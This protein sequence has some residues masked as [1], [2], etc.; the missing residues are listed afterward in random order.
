VTGSVRPGRN[1]FYCALAA[2]G[3]A[4]LAFVTDAA[5]AALSAMALAASA[6]L[7]VDFLQLR[8]VP[9]SVKVRRQ[10]P[11]AAGRG[12][13]FD[14]ALSLSNATALPLKMEVRDIVPNEA[15]PNYSVRAIDIPANG[16]A[17]L[18]ER[19]QIPTR[20]KFSFGPV[21]LRAA[22]RFGMLERQWEAECAADIKVLPATALS[23][24]ALEKD[25]RA[26][27]TLLEKKSRAPL[28]GDGMEFE[29]LSEFRDG[30]DPRRIDWRASARQLRPIVRRFTVEQHRDMLLVL[31]CGRLMGIA[32]DYRDQKGTKLDRAVDSAL[33]LANIAIDKGDRCGLALFDDKVLGF[34]PPQGG[35][36]GRKA[37]IENLYNVQSRLREANFAAM[38]A[39]LQNRQQKRALI[40]ILSD[41]V[42]VET[43][44]LF[45]GA[46]VALARRHVVIFAALRTPLLSNLLLEPV[47]STMDLTRK[48]VALRLLRAREKALHTLDHTGVHVLDVE[49]RQL[50]VPLVNKYILLRQQN[51]L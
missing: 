19:L 23:D 17:G 1:L 46:L 45:R 28:R 44:E 34:L 48:G 8:K 39:T 51:A 16:S 15:A 35:A 25:E 37:L 42:D 43:S 13:H 7:L 21:W 31:D 2:A 20:G 41:L 22:G 14:V 40:V 3:L 5:V 38:F 24:D 30:D 32:A 4:A 33:L 6:L 11:L 10:M 18:R 50:T 9:P 27:I 36:H 49:P 29:S 12:A 47:D 26:E